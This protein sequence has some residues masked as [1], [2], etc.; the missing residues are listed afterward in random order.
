MLASL[1]RPDDWRLWL[2]NANGLDTAKLDFIEFESS[3]VAY[4]AAIAGRGVAIGQ[5]VLIEDHLAS[6]RLVRPL[7]QVFDHGAH[8]YRLVWAKNHR[9]TRAIQRVS[10]AL[11]VSNAT[12]KVDL[13]DCDGYF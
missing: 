2:V 11:V 8:T 3:A 9:N 1:H 5:Q 12:E 10:D 4:Q 6:G 7:P 13:S